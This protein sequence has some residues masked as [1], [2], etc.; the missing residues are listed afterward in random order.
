MPRLSTLFTLHPNPAILFETYFQLVSFMFTVMVITMVIIISIL[1]VIAKVIVMV[2]F[3]VIFFCHGA[4]HC[5]PIP[6]WFNETDL[7]D[8]QPKTHPEEGKTVTNP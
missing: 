6:S 7:Q 5:H 2:M 8:N 1:M 3:M 4:G